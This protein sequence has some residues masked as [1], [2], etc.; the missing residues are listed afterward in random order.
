MS[1]AVGEMLRKILIVLEA[2]PRWNPREYPI[3]RIYLIFLESRIIG[4]HFAA[5]TVGLPLL[6]F[7]WWAPSLRKTFLFLQE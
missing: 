1:S 4:P 2:T 5:D 6:N 7:F 3:I